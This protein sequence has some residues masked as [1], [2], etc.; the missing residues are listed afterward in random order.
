MKHSAYEIYM[1]TNKTEHTFPNVN[2]NLYTE[3]NLSCA[4]IWQ[5]L[6]SLH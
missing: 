2:D 5:L 1:Q 6:N 3:F 4:K